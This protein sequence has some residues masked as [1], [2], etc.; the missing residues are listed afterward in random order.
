MCGNR[1]G[2][3]LRSLVLLMLFVI[4]SL[5][6]AS[7]ISGA[8][9]TT[10]PDGT[11]VNAN[12]YDDPTTVY[13]NG[14][15]Q[16]KNGSL[17][18][19]GIYYFQVTI[20]SGALL[21]SNDSALDRLVLVDDSGRIVGRCQTDG[22]LLPPYNGPYPPD[23]N[24]QTPYPHP[25]GDPNTANGNVPVQLWPFDQT[26]NQGGEYKA[27]LIVR[28]LK[29]GN[30]NYV[31]DDNTTIDNDGIHLHY[32]L[33]DTKTDNFK[34]KVPPPPVNPPIE[35][36]SGTKFYDKDFDGFD[37]TPENDNG[38]LPVQNFP[39]HVDVVYPPNY[40]PLDG[41][42]N[43]IPPPPGVTTDGSGNW[44]TGSFDLITDP[45]GGYSFQAPE[46]ASYSVY[47]N[48]PAGSEWLETAPTLGGQGQVGYEGTVGSENITGLDFGNIQQ[49]RIGGIKFYDKNMN[50]LLDQ[51]EVGIDGITIHVHV[52]LPDNS[53]ADEDDVTS[54]GG[55]W[56]SGYY[57]DGS[58]YVATE[59]PPGPQWFETTGPQT[60]QIGPGTQVP[61]DDP[62]TV[63]G[64]GS[65]FPYDVTYNIPDMNTVNFGNIL[66]ANIDGEKFFDRNMNGTVDPGDPGLGGFTIHLVGTEPDNTPIDTTK[67][68]DPVTGKF[69]FGPYPDGTTFTITE[70]NVP[71]NWQQTNTGPITGTLTAGAGP[72]TI[73]ST[74]DDSTGNNVGNIPLAPIFGEKFDDVDENGQQG[75]G[76]PGLPGF[77]F[78]IAGQLPNGQP[79]PP[80]T[81]ATSD[82]SGHFQF[83]PY[84]IGTTF[85]IHEVPMPGWLE[86][87]PDPIPGIITGP[88]PVDVTSSVPPA[89]VLVGNTKLL[90]ISGHKFYDKNMN[91]AMDGGEQGLA[92]FT[93]TLSGHDPLNHPL[94]MTTQTL[95]DG[96]FVFHNIPDGSVYSITEAPVPAGWLETT[97]DPQGGTLSG[98]DVNNINIG[99]ILTAKIKGIKFYDRNMNGHQDANDPVVPGI[100]IKITGTK[101]N[102]GPINDSMQ[103]LADGSYSFG[104]YPDGSTYT[105]TEVLPAGWLNTTPVTISGTLNAGTP[106]SVNSILP[107]VTGQNFGNIM[108]TTLS[109]DKF[110]DS[111]ANNAYDAG[112]PFIKGFKIVITW[113]KPNGT[114]GTDTYFTNG[115]GQ[116]FFGPYPDGTTFVIKE[117]MPTTSWVQSFPASKTYSGS[118]TFVGPVTGSS[119]I[120]PQGGY[121]FGNFLV[122]GGNGLTPGYWSNSNG[123]NSANAIGW[124]T[125]FA[126]LNTSNLRNLNGTIQTWPATAQGYKSF[127]TWLGAGT[128][129]S[130]MATQLSVHLAAF[131]LNVMSGKIGGSTL[132]YA[133]GSNSANSMGYATAN[134]LIAEAIASLAANGYTVAS[135]PI[136]TYQE[137]LK[138]AFA[139]ANMQ[140]SGSTVLPPVTVIVPSPY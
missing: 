60:G 91:G 70:Q 64:D 101:P 84:P 63:E 86:T 81:T 105:I 89:N 116:F 123:Y 14:G 29:D 36:I 95:A 107:D 58:T 68:S 31:M 102:G 28:A 25:D 48:P 69:S 71:G 76:E 99:N 120:P 115:S 112:E 52:T 119:T 108:T 93:I 57:P 8:I 21:L 110:Y 4:G 1:P 22:T 126:K 124:T 13:L 137:K 127:Q 97:V 85:V 34:I 45:S 72:Y 133:P 40:L 24:A 83:G 10:L 65:I 82:G 66:V 77:T 94:N 61:L 132:I 103:T 90:N 20:P 62:G 88:D 7:Q 73:G 12:I 139:G 79:L 50:H 56:Q 43:P 32:K 42:G 27:W 26:T 117:I 128:N 122:G 53:T 30:G 74:M 134:A 5:V 100:T 104:P 136:R 55:H 78:T 114:T 135:G 121:R 130:N 11:T 75:P 46:G 44:I 18:P 140:T 47:E 54:G 35:D 9:F 3:G 38:E 23:P 16:N 37:N 118:I 98:N 109:G 33:D 49:G 15:P 51:G 19:A 87:T 125:V 17:L 2:W 138:N 131:E 129:A 96:S 41:Q 80:P 92:G 113:A 59:T 111:N 39:I 6:Q 67:P 106:T